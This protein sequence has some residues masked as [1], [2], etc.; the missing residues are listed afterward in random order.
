MA[1]S[2]THTTPDRWVTRGERHLSLARRRADERAIAEDLELWL[3][4]DYGPGPIVY[5][6]PVLDIE[7]CEC[8]CRRCLLHDDCGGCLT[9]HGRG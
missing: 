9:G 2:T 6:P 3:G 1:Y 7:D 4:P 8:S 5:E